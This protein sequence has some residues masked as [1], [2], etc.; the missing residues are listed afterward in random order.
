M[1]AFAHADVPGAHLVF[2]GEGPRTELESCAKSLGL[3]APDTFPWLYQSIQ[4]ASGILCIGHNGFAFGIR[5][6]WCGR[7][8]SDAVRMSGNRERSRGAGPDLVLA[9]K[10]GHIS[11]CGDVKSLAAL[12]REVLSD[13]ERLK[14]MG[15]AA[16]LRMAT[17]SPKEN[18]AGL[19][20][21][22][23]RSLELKGHR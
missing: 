12:L 1:K 13:R 18:I 7:K 9:G 11:P 20:L 4:L 16:R 22:I 15:E 17:W 3:D 10:N 5:T 2:A 23:E 6:F 14:R 8:R 21:A 19:V